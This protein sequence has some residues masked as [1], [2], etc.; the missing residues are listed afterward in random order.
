MT[1]DSTWST[2]V[3]SKYPETRPI[4]TAMALANSPPNR[5]TSSDSRVP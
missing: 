5:P 4:A 3:P 2:A 1:N